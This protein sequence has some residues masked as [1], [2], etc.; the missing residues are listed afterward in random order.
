MN[1]T[2]RLNIMLEAVLYESAINGLVEHVSAFPDVPR[3][4]HLCEVTATILEDIDS[5]A[6]M[7]SFVA[8]AV[9][10]LE[11]ERRK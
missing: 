8:M 10:M 5:P 6:K 11:E 4:V 2:Q 7:A 3:E 1:E 9:V